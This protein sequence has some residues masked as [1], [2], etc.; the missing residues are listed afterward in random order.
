[1]VKFSSTNGL[2]YFILDS[3]SIRNVMEE[4]MNDV[5]NFTSLEDWALN[6]F[7]KIPFDVKALVIA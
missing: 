4:I 1:M 3:H 6:F 5:D 7:E 2:E